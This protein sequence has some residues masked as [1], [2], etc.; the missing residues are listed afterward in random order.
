LGEA[1]LFSELFELVDVRLELSF[2]HPKAGQLPSGCVVLITP[3][4]FLEL[5]GE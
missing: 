4:L 5:F 2:L 1:E 3:G